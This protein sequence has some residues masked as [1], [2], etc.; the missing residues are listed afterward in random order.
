MK[1]PLALIMAVCCSLG[2]V[3]A[4]S[5]VP[6]AQTTCQKRS[7]VKYCSYGFVLDMC[8]CCF[9]CGKGP[10]AACGGQWAWHGRCG[11]GLECRYP[12]VPKGDVSPP[13]FL[14]G[15]PGRCVSTNTT[16]SDKINVFFSWIS[17]F[18]QNTIMG[19]D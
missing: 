4:L 2:R 17:S 7:M 14:S 13:F 19:R 6:C 11:R 1:I 8:G 5:C 9:V 10:G 3:R 16:I 12:E 15:L 18:I